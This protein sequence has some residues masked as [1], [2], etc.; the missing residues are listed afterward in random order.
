MYVSAFFF[1]THDIV[2]LVVFTTNDG[3]SAGKLGPFVGKVRQDI[4]LSEKKYT[5]YVF[6]GPVTGALTATWENLDDKKWKVI[7]I[8]IVLT[9]FGVPLIKKQ[10]PADQT[11]IW[12]MTYTDE[13]FRVLYA[14]GGKNKKLENIYILSKATPI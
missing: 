10:F 1:T 12:R 7:F 3:S 8:D 4:V 9:L 5:N 13:N 2:T 11:G 14:Q 6:L